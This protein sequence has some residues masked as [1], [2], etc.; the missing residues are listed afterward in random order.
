MGYRILLV[1]TAVLIGVIAAL[2][3]G[4]LT[5]VGGAHLAAAVISG[6]GAFIAVVPLVLFVERELGLFSSG[7]S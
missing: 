3:T 7:D 2:A 6:G 1:L 4:I 5:V